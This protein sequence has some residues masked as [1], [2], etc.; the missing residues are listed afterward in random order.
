MAYTAV[1]DWVQVQIGGGGGYSFMQNMADNALQ[2]G[3]KRPYKDTNA[4]FA[5][6][7][8]A[9]SLCNKTAEVR[10]NELKV[11]IDERSGSV[12]DSMVAL[13]SVLDELIANPNKCMP[14]NEAF[15]EYAGKLPNIACMPNKKEARRQFKDRILSKNG[16]PILFLN[17]GGNTYVMLLG[18]PLNNISLCRSIDFVLDCGTMGEHEQFDWSLVGCHIPTLLKLLSTSKDRAILVFILSSIVSPTRLALL[19]GMQHQ[20]TQ[21]VKKKVEEFL[22]EVERKQKEAEKE[23]EK[24]IEDIISSLQTEIEQDAKDL[25]SKRMRLDE[26]E[27]ESRNT[28][29]EMKKQRKEKLQKDS[30][31]KAK[32]RVAKRLFKKW[33][34]QLMSQQGKGKGRFSID[35]GAEKA[36][37]EVLQ[38]QLQA[39]RRRWGEE[40][41]GYLEHEKRIHSKEMKKIANKYLKK[42]G[43]KPVLSKETVRSWGKCRNKRSRQSKQHR[44][45]NLW[46]HLR[47]EKKQQDKHINIHYNRA[48]VKNYTRFSFSRSSVVHGKNL[49]VRRAIDDKA[50]IR[51]GTSEGFCRPLHTPVQ[52]NTGPDSHFQLPTA[53]YPDPVGYVSPGV[54]LLVNNMKETEH[55][56]RDKFVSDDV[57]VYVNCKP[58][59]IYPSTAT[60]WANDLFLVRYRFQYE[61]E[62]SAIEDSSTLNTDCLKKVLPYLVAVRDSIF[63]FELMTIK[64]DYEKVAQ[65]GDHLSRELL[66]VSILLKRLEVALSTLEEFRQLPSVEKLTKYLSLLVEHLKCIREYF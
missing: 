8:V 33:K 43:K 28:D 2:R 25:S 10:Q 61:H 53:D 58:K 38:E 36:I 15:Y 40:G 30:K 27:I 19:L 52:M 5:F 17:D 3:K 11:S 32:K 44:G 12:Q 60:N 56:G 20:H 21:K 22:N 42:A 48:H 24:H 45:L 65:G 66:R 55:K 46:A 16:L 9:V 26:E 59:H 7:H 57:S 39:H 13:S 64:E 47:A 54:V 14:F 62:M 37:Y 35:R 51:C 63:Q 31:Q 41:T 6:R 23:S 50:Y 29:A 1:V 49:V 4:S 34:S 18:L